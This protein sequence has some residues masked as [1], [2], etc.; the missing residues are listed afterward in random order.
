MKLLDELISKIEKF[1][2]T[3]TTDELYVLR[4]LVFEDEGAAIIIQKI[5]KMIVYRENGS[6]SMNE[7][8]NK[9]IDG[10]YRD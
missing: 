6:H 3:L 5:D 2:V 4:G 9:I 1:L 7:E 8:F 10:G